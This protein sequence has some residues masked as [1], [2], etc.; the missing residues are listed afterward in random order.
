MDPDQT[1]LLSDL[2]PHWLSKKLLKYFIRWQKQ[3]TFVVIGANSTVQFLYKA[4]FGAHMNCIISESC[5][6]E[7]FYKGIIGK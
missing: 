7:N 5:Y 3:T 4:M 2:G 1:A 6:E